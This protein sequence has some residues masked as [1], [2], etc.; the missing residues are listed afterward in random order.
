MKSIWGIG[1]LFGA[2]LSVAVFATACGRVEEAPGEGTRVGEAAQPAQCMDCGGGYEEPEDPPPPPPDLCGGQ[3][4]PSGA[5]PTPYP[6]WDQQFREA[7]DYARRAGFMT[8][9]RNFHAAIYNNVEVW[10]TFLV[11]YASGAEF[12]DV[13]HYELSYVDRANV[14]QFM[15]LTHD[16]A[17]RNGFVGG[18]PTFHQGSMNGLDVRGIYLFHSNAVEFREVPGCE[19]G[20]AGTTDVGRIFRAVNDYS[21]RKG[22]AGGFPTFH[23]RRLTDGNTVYGVILF[24]PGMLDWRDV[25]TGEYNQGCG[26]NWQSKCSD[27]CDFDMPYYYDGKCRNVAPPPP[28]PPPCGS[29][30][31]QCCTSG[32]PCRTD[33]YLTCISNRC[34]YTP[35]SSEP[36]SGT[37]TV[38]MSLTS[39]GSY[40]NSS[41]GN[42]T[43]SSTWALI[44]KV[45]NNTGYK[46]RIRHT[47][48][49]NRGFD[50]LLENGAE[51]DLS[52][53]NLTYAGGWSTT[54]TFDCSWNVPPS[55]LGITVEYLQP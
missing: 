41:V 43:L 21:V 30:T 19:L 1:K 36:S 2:L 40:A 5:T 23:T 22:F 54:I 17:T 39:C 34:E 50:I 18:I 37:S 44:K 46:A 15:R 26:G 10:G 7:H 53:A 9:F 13:Y 28:P 45:R 20:H 49:Y 33:A 16:Y 51:T 38:T 35:P 55:D 32:S 25:K 48:K 52:S 6:A 27:G 8:G 47:D 4:Y 29:Y 11:P 12:R 24:R 3:S 31:E 42:P 14:P